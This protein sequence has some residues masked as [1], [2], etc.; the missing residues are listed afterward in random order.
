MRTKYIILF[1]MMALCY[2]LTFAQITGIRGE[3][4]TPRIMH[5]TDLP[6]I[7]EIEMG[8]VIYGHFNEGKPPDYPKYP[9]PNAESLPHY[10]IDKSAF[11]P[12]PMFTPTTGVN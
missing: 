6:N 8:P 5:I 11:Y 12:P 3:T 1:L 2:H 10:T 7:G 4:V 9:A